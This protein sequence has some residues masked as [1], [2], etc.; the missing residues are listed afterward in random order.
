MYDDL[1]IVQ[2]N[3]KKYVSLIELKTTTKK[4]MWAGEVKAAIRQ[5]QL[6][7]WLLKEELEAIGYPLYKFFYFTYLLTEYRRET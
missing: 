7:Q 5:L 4:Y 2:E 1:Y 3:G 6:Y